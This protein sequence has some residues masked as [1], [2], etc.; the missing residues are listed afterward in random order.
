MMN[1]LAPELGRRKRAAW[2]AYR[3]IEYVVKKTVNT[4]LRAYHFNTTVLPASSSSRR[5][6]NMCVQPLKGVLADNESI[7]R[8]KGYAQIRRFDQI[9]EAV[10]FYLVVDDT[11]LG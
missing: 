9:C 6:H 8:M 11:K 2:G 7:F 10:D 5:M 1:V 4:R 3:S